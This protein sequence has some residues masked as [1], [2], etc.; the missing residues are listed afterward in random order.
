MP[1]LLPCLLALTLLPTTIHAEGPLAFH[2]TFNEK[3]HKGPFTGRPY[4]LRPPRKTNQP[5]GSRNGSPPS[6]CS[7]WDAKGVSP[8]EKIV[9]DKTAIAY[10]TP[11]D[12][13]TKG[14]Y[15]A[16]AVIALAPGTRHF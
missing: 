9:L 12:R 5:A 8:G 11:L 6:P 4:A 2:L 1:R 15:T 10:P 16:Q 14:T 3:Q 13:I 7:A